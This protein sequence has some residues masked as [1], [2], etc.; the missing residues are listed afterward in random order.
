M[1]KA[2]K[3]NVTKTKGSEVNREEEVARREMEL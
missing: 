1:E 2:E 3:E